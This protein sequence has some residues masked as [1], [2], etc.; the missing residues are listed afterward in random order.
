MVDDLQLCC[1]WIA[2]GAWVILGGE[3][4]MDIVKPAS[5]DVADPV[6]NVQ[7]A[8][9]W[10]WRV[11]VKVCGGVF[12]QVHQECRWFIALHLLRSPKDGGCL[13]IFEPT[14]QNCQARW[15]PC[16][17]RWIGLAR[18]SACCQNPQCISAHPHQKN[19][20]APLVV[21]P[22]ETWR[23]AALESFGAFLVHAG[24]TTWGPSQLQGGCVSMVAD[25]C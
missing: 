25:L 16:M 2:T 7:I 9:Y 8:I 20:R 10:V 1:T 12:S 18:S 17:G 3:K 23:R 5:C 4:Y 6:L 13:R 22:G 11:K 15:Q 14:M 19:R 21:W 24:G